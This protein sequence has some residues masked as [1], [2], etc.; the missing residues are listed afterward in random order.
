MG[1]DL[2]GICDSSIA[3]GSGYDNHLTREMI[4][5][6][7]KEKLRLHTTGKIGYVVTLILNRKGLP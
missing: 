4:C 3:W 6:V 7:R 5:P 2:S 1:E